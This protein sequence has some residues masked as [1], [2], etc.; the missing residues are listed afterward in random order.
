MKITSF[1]ESNGFMVVTGDRTNPHAVEVIY[2]YQDQVRKADELLSAFLE[3]L[4]VTG[5]NGNGGRGSVDY[6]S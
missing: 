3:G 1:W 5:R 6:V 2:K 4:G